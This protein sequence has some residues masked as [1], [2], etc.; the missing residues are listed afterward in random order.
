M[1]FDDVGVRILVGIFDL[2]FHSVRSVFTFLLLI[3]AA[4]IV[5]AATVLLG[6]SSLLIGAKLERSRHQ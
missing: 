6:P 5:I 1:S 4:V 2:F 3:L